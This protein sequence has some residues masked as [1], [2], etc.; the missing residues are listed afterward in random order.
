MS[1]AA[2]K[3]ASPP[4]QG[5]ARAIFSNS[6]SVLIARIITIQA[7]EVSILEDSRPSPSAFRLILP[8]DRWSCPEGHLSAVSEE[9]PDEQCRRKLARRLF[10]E[11]ESY[12]DFRDET[13]RFVAEAIALI[14]HNKRLSTADTLYRLTAFANLF[15]VFVTIS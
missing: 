12:E 6:I 11:S 7:S 1:R 4:Q 5:F 3:Q 14:P 8:P 15:N 9:R 10:P 2:D 13:L